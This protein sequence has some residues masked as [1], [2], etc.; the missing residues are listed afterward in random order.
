MLMSRAQSSGGGDKVQIRAEDVQRRFRLVKAI[1]VLPTVDQVAV[2]L[3]GSV[4]D[5]QSLG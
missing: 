2:G 5:H 3:A 4:P 1:P